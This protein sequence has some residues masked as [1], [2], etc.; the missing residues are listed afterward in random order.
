MERY[1]L[2]Y[3]MDSTLDEWR[4]RYYDYMKMQLDSTLWAFGNHTSVNHERTI[5]HQ[6]NYVIPRKDSL[7]GIYGI[8][9]RAFD[10]NFLKKKS[11]KKQASI[12]NQNNDTLKKHY[13]YKIFSAFHLPWLLPDESVRKINETGIYVDFISDSSKPWSQSIT[14][15]QNWYSSMKLLPFNEVISE[16]HVQELKAI[17]NQLV[18]DFRDSDYEAVMVFSAEVFE[19]KI[20]IDVFR[21][22]GKVSIEL[23]HGIP[24]ATL[25]TEA[26]KVDYF[27]VYGEQLKQD[28]IAMGCDKNKLY[29]AGDCK[30]TENFQTPIQL[31]C[32]MEDVLVI[33]SATWREYQCEWEFE[34][35]AINDR[36][37]L[38]TYLYSVENVLKRNGLTHARLRPH[39][40]VMKDWLSKY[41]DMDFYELDYLDLSESLDK[42]TCCIGQNSTVVIEAINHGVSYLL[43]E[44]GDGKHYITGS[45]LYPPFDGS[46]KW[47]KVANSEEELDEMIKS[48]Y[49]PSPR[50]G[51]QY[52]EPF[53]PEV[54]RDVLYSHRN[55]QKSANK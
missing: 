46:N 4:K 25:L 55:V 29:V 54:I 5:E 51:K 39:P 40:H 52:M 28:A 30:Y 33:T 21:D 37:L 9:R 32:S 53:K 49:S 23:L 11:L 10:R 31:R 3:L 7:K 44:P 15:L 14:R 38:I 27:L 8:L 2:K 18:E 41:V 1:I 50:I 13:D 17:Y 22:L 34:K 19:A 48:R 42:A 12:Q 20:L 16:I 6:Q 47:L 35:F 24:G 43:Y 26:E 36:S 45:L